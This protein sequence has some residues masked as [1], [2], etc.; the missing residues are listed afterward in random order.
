MN[1]KDYMWSV[2]NKLVQDYG[3]STLQAP[4]NTIEDEQKI[5]PLNLI[6]KVKSENIYVRLVY[7]DFIWPNHL[8]QDMG[9]LRNGAKQV[10]DRLNGGSLRLLNL[11]VFKS[12]PSEEVQ[13]LIS[14]ADRGNE[15]N[16]DTFFGYIDLEKEEIGIPK[17]SFDSKNLTI[18]PFVYYLTKNEPVESEV[19]VEEIRTHEQNRL[20]EIKNIFSHGKPYLTYIFIIINAIIFLLMTFN[21]GSNDTGVLLEFGAKE[22]YLIM[23]GE[24]WRLIT[25]IFLHIGFLHFALNNVALFYLGKLAESIFGSVRFFFIYMVS[26]IIGN[27]ASFI[28]LPESVSAGASGAI[29]G[30]FGALLYFGLMYQELF[31]R[32]I[33]RDII[34]IIVINIA[35]GLMMPDID[36]TAHLGG[37]IGG[38]IVAAIIH[39]PNLKRRKWIVTIVSIIA[40]LG[41]SGITWVEVTAEDLRGS[42]A[43]YIEGQKAL[44]QGD[45]TRADNI[46]NFLVNEYPDV[47]YNHFNVANLAAKQGDYPKAIEFYKKTLE[48]DKYFYEAYYNLSLI[49]IINDNYNQAEA[50]LISA[51]EISPNFQAA[52]DL[53]DEIKK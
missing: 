2:A 47:S 30:I 40:I 33:G 49:A 23:S 37:L 4:K 3:F 46:F 32:T 5:A 25:P 21:G 35:F 24:Y 48:L 20:N 10:L 34:V 15:K 29:F 14:S 41:I 51:L 36:N 11:Y 22:S 12:T 44:D 42:Q 16:I 52:K 50:Y 45:L 27:I 38:F 26:G 1:V 43:V 19:M 13:K 31:F 17:E 7:L 18:D 53:L 39:L 6:K 28:L 9:K 8:E